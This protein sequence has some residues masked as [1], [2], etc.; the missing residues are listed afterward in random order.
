ME[1]KVVNAVLNE[2][3]I[4]FLKKV[5]LYDQF[6]QKQILCECCKKPITDENIALIKFDKKYVFIC[7]D[8]ECIDTIE[9]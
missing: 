3:I 2:D 5:G 9:Q 8:L 6:V 4:G 1:R 7:D